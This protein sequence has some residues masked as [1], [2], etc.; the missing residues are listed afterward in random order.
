MR[1]R[2]GR[3]SAGFEIHLW[4][5]YVD[6]DLLREGFDILC[7]SLYLGGKDV[8]QVVCCLSLLNGD[9]RRLSIWDEDLR[10]NCGTSSHE[11]EHGLIDKG[12]HDSE[13]PIYRPK[14][15]RLRLRQKKRVN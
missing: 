6:Q 10:R 8:V 1:E 12:D 2:D 7:V 4:F 9:L 11:E 3:G 14:I 5:W 15:L 13:L